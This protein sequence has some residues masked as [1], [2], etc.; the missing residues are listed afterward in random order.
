MFVYKVKNSDMIK[1]F[2]N[3]QACDSKFASSNITI[4]RKSELIGIV[5]GWH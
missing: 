5:H 4:Y 1:F 2:F 3:S